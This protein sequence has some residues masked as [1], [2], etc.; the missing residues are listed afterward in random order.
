MGDD[1]SVAWL[2]HA[3]I[4]HGRV[5]MAGFVGYMIH[6]NGIRWPWA[7]STSVRTLLTGTTPSLLCL[8]TA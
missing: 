5:A 4:K 8:L 7:L 1:R 3:E 6:E 2:R